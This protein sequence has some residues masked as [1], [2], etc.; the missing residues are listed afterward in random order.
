MKNH[1]DNVE[2]VYKS[3]L[4]SQCGTCAALCPHSAI[5]LQWDGK[6]GYVL[7]VDEGLCNAC[8]LCYE[9]CPGHEVDF[10]DLSSRFLG[11]GTDN[12]RIGRY[13]SIYAGHTIQEKLR[14]EAASGGIVTALLIAALKKGVIDGAVVTRM[15]P[16]SPLE[17]LTI[18]ATT[19]EQ[20]FEA[21]GSKYCPVAANL[22]LSEILSSEGRF[23]VVG[24][25]CHI[26]GLRKAQAKNR[27]LR[28]KVAISISIF[29]GL[30]MSPA[31][32]RV[33]LHRYGISVEDISQIRYRGAGWPGGL[34]VELRDGRTHFEPYRGYFDDHFMCYEMHRCNLCTDSFGELADI[35]CGDAWLPEFTSND[36]QG[37]SVVVVRSQRG[38]ELIS[39]LGPGVLALNPLSIDRA[40]QSQRKALMWK[41]DWLHAKFA[42]T[43]LT[44]KETP[45]Y[46][47]NQPLTRLSGYFRWIR[48]VFSRYLHRV[49]HR[50][51][52]LTQEK[53]NL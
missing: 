2:V 6:S 33:M 4:C 53:E 32:T 44:G 1:I 18:L 9:I 16:E 37:S 27:R 17:P 42:L 8:G 24:L 13:I 46:K 30:N 36:N 21:R 38:E 49:W 3:G 25:P 20:I 50:L 43:R 23:A 45:V 40:E 11:D 12:W 19:E 14:W 41:K 39:S 29:C 28:E 48:T 35:S 26:Q 15:K 10:E 34:Q 51:K 31:G 7:S 22:S 47:H 5:Q 52:G